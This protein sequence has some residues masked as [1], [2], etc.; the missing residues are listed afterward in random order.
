[1]PNRKLIN[2]VFTH[3]CT[4]RGLDGGIVDP[5]QIN[6]KILAE[7]DRAS[8]QYKLTQAFLLGQDQFGMAYI[9]AARSGRI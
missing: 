4:Q 1:M 9:S 5:I 2:Q 8:E 6:D 3:L 7:L